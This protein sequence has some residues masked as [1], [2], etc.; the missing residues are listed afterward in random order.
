VPRRRFERREQIRTP[1][2][3]QTDRIPRVRKSLLKPD[4]FSLDRSSRIG[5]VD[6]RAALSLG[7]SI[8]DSS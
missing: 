2:F 4:V 5:K 7:D 1:R 8:P 3:A 6:R